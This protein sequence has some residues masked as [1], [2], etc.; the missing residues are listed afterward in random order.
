MLILS[1]GLV[2]PTPLRDKPK[3]F[4][5][6]FIQIINHL[7]LY[8]TTANFWI[9]H[10]AN[11]DDHTVYIYLF[12]CSYL[13]TWGDHSMRSI[14][15]PWYPG[16]HVFS[17]MQGWHLYLQ[18]RHGEGSQKKNIKAKNTKTTSSKS[19]ARKQLKTHLLPLIPTHLYTAK[20]CVHGLNLWLINWF[21]NQ[22]MEDQW[23]LV[24]VSFVIILNLIFITNNNQ[25]L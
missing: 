15:L 23:H 20:Y 2:G 5:F 4:L 3:Y 10:S 22:I 21:T 18:N 17:K 7:S 9:T 8:R 1:Q 11:Y 24:R 12:I 6:F 19:A 16:D 14:V 13:Q 25:K